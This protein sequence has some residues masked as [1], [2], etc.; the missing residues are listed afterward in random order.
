MT[1]LTTDCLFDGD[2]FE[3]I[4]VIRTQP[5]AKVQCELRGG[6]LARISSEIER[7]AVTNLIAPRFGDFAIGDRLSTWIGTSAIL[8]L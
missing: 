2:R 8:V 5:Q 4:G 1:T 3:F 7:R 6:S